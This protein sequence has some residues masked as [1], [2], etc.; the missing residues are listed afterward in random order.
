MALIKSHFDW[1]VF[2]KAFAAAR[3]VF[4]LSRP[5][6]REETY[7]LTDQIR[8]ASRSVTANLAEAWRKRIYEAAFV[9]KV[10]DA[11]AE[12]AETQTWLAHAVDCGY[13]PTDVA[14]ELHERYEEILR[15]L[16]SIRCNADQW[17]IPADGKK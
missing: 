15:M 7:S 1:E 3:S 11:E 8:R 5:F 13:L 17:V 9:S 6:P 4:S 2:K 16:V 10:N 12:A 14:Q